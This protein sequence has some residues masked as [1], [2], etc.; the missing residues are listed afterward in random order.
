MIDVLFLNQIL[1]K[2]KKHGTVEFDIWKY[3]RN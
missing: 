1:I 2:L 3:E